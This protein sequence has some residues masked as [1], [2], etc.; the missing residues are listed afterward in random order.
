MRHTAPRNDMHLKVYAPR[1][2]VSALQRAATRRLQSQNNYVRQASLEQL[3]RDGEAVVALEHGE[4][5]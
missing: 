5:A 1:A 4:A 2:L 3:Q